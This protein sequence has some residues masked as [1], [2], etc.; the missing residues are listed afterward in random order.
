MTSPPSW[1]DSPDKMDRSY[2]RWRNV[3][4]VSV[5]LSICAWGLW[6]QYVAVPLTVLASVALLMTLF[7]WFRRDDLLR[8]AP[9]TRKP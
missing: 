3:S 5:G 2:R 7:T 1:W 6:L 8:G 9:P 4:V